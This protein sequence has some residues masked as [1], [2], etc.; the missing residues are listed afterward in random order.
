M[1]EKSHGNCQGCA[2]AQ[3]DADQPVKQQVNAG[4]RHAHM[5]EAGHEERGG[6]DS[7][8]RNLLVA[9]APG[10]EPGKQSGDCETAEQPGPFQD[11]V[12]NVHREQS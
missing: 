9:D 2:P 4:R 8:L 10:P 11:A 6:H 12:R 7:D 1:Q 3:H 5:H